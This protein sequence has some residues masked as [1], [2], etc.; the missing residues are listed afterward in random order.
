M[1]N[2]PKIFICFTLIFFSVSLFSQNDI[3][4]FY[5]KDKNTKEPISFCYVVVKGKNSSSVSDEQGLVKIK[6]K[7][8]DTLVI[9]QFGYLLK[10]NTMSQ[11]TLSGGT[12]LLEKKNIQL[13]EV[14]VTAKAVEIFREKDNTVYIDF[15]FY[16]DLV[17][18][19]INKGNKF[20]TL[21]LS[22]KNGETIAEARLKVDCEKLYK[23]CFNNIHLITADSIYQVYYDYQ[24]IHLLPPFSIS[25]YYSLLQPC[26]SFYN[27]T[28][29]FK[30]KLY[31][32]LKAD[33]TYYNETAQTRKKMI[34]VADSVAIRGFNMDYDINYFLNLRRKGLGYPY[35]VGEINKHIDQLRE[36]IALPAS[37]ASLLRPL[38]SEVRRID[39]NFILF[40]YTNKEIY[41]FSMSG[42]L[43]SKSKLMKFET[44]KPGILIDTEAPNYVFS[45]Q[46]KSTGILNLYRYDH[47]KNRLSHK[48]VLSNF[49]YIQNYK[50]KEN[51]IYFIHIKRTSHDVK[52][53]LVKVPLR[54]DPVLNSEL[55][56]D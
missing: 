29:I 4:R 26:Q 18:C 13:D 52:T 17:L 16:D 33:Y 24:R 31:K 19:L 42:D 50:I 43:H 53:K 27:D 1:K 47:L 2:H 40:D 25:N 28:Y 55:A 22:D 15:E 34:C 10:K 37:Y 12:V 9:Y 36:E 30:T 54:W 49:H 38:E 11:I 14:T 32:N 8:D 35:S 46:N 20:N 51:Y 45:E 5:V 41:R 3:A 21:L 6:A 39:T 23:D 48:F 44:I 56:H 7:P